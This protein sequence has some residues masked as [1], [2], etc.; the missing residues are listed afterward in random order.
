MRLLCPRKSR[1][2]NLRGFWGEP[3]SWPLPSAAGLF[4][5]SRP[6]APLDVP[7]L[8]GA[9]LVPCPGA[10]HCP[11]LLPSLR[12]CPLNPCRSLFPR[13][14]SLPLRPATPPHRVSWMS[15]SGHGTFLFGPCFPVG[16]PVSA[17]I[18]VIESQLASSSLVF[19]SLKPIDFSTSDSI[20][21][22]LKSLDW[23]PG[24]YGA[25]SKSRTWHTRLPQ[26]TPATLW[27]VT[28]V[29]LLWRVSHTWPLAG[30]R[31][32]ASC[33]PFS[34]TWWRP[35]FPKT[36]DMCHLLWE[37]APSPSNWTQTLFPSHLLSTSHPPPHRNDLRV[38]WLFLP[39]TSSSHLIPYS[40]SRSLLSICPLQGIM[41]TVEG[42]EII[43]IRKNL[44]ASLGRM[45]TKDTT[46]ETCECLIPIKM[47]YL[48]RQVYRQSPV[49]TEKKE[50]CRTIRKSS[51]K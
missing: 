27:L 32:T 13:A 46:R 34:P 39:V 7:W 22:L 37:A 16:P 14:V 50:L 10:L 31:S 24:D 33:H 28:L 43:E 8:P 45:G 38:A 23:L 9:H 11:C 4:P 48:Q 2:W 18:P 44:I 30:S 21:F 36:Q 17:K 6:A 5:S 41:P 15:E 19:L 26:Q 40:F 51:R 35:I 47:W 25:S 49:D 3:P 12:V 1:L 42:G 29:P 20:N